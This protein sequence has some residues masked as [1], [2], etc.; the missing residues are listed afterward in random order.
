MVNEDSTLPRDH[1]INVLAKS[2]VG[3]DGDDDKP[4]TTA[5]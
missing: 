2:E 1:L 5:D 4:R 3:L